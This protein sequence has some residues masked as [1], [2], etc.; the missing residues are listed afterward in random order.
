MSHFVRGDVE[1]LVVHAGFFD[2]GSQMSFFRA[3][4]G[5]HGVTGAARRVDHDVIGEKVRAFGGKAELHQQIWNVF[6]VALRGRIFSRDDRVEF[7]FA[8][9]AARTETAVPD[10][11]WLERTSEA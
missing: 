5:T 8:V 1:S 7:R 3:H 9:L 2:A 4:L 11:K 10:V 6:L